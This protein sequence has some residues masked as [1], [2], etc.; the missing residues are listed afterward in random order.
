MWPPG[1]PKP[2]LLVLV[3]FITAAEDEADDEDDEDEDEFEDNIEVV[4]AWTVMGAT[5]PVCITSGTIGRNIHKHGLA[6]W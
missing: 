6:W 4:V 5:G 2:L 1:A 3:V